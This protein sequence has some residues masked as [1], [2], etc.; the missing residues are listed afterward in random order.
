MTIKIRN[1]G[2]QAKSFGIPIFE[3]DRDGKWVTGPDGKPVVA[4]TPD[5]LNPTWRGK[6]PKVMRVGH[7]LSKDFRLGSSRDHAHKAGPGELE[8]LKPEQPISEEDFRALL[9]ADASRMALLAYRESG[10]VAVYGAEA[11]FAELGIK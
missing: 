3:T 11:I 9:S 6:K 10:E 7:A 2:L 4:R 5:Q 1:L 8:R